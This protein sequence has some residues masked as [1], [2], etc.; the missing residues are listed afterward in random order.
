[1][2]GF[3]VRGRVRIKIRF[4]VRVRVEVMTCL[5]LAFINGANVVHSQFCL[6]SEQKICNVI[7]YS[8]ECK[9]TQE[10]EIPRK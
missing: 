9:G 7:C 4:R 2:I 6:P 8:T 1:M 10:E 5:T 3:L